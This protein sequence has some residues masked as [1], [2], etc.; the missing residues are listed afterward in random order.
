[1]SFLDSVLSNT[2]GVAYRAYTGNVDPWTKQEQVDQLQADLSQASGGTLTPDQAAAIAGS[3]ITDAL[4][5]AP[6]GGADPS[7]STALPRVPI[8]GQL[9]SVSSL[10]KLDS[11]VNGAIVVG[12]LIAGFYVYQAFGRPIAHEFRRR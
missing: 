2:V 8:L 12:V 5:S 7:Q 6:G 10:Q 1:M 3:T 9:G 4:T 11:L